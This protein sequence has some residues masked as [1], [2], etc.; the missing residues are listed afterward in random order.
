MQLRPQSVCVR[1]EVPWVWLHKKPRTV[2]FS[3]SSTTSC[4]HMGVWF[5]L[6]S[7]TTDLFHLLNRCLPVQ[8]TRVIPSIPHGEPVLLAQVLSSQDLFDCRILCEKAGACNS[9]HLC[10]CVT[11]VIFTVVQTNPKIVPA[12]QM[13][14]REKI[15]VTS[16]L[17]VVKNPELTASSEVQS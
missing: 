13:L 11:G 17:V 8:F 5:P 15:V 16:A 14:Q 6:A 9:S 10:L 4:G 1:L 7:A 3:W 2:A 12:L